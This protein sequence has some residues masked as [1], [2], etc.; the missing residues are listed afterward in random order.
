M[1]SL[2]ITVIAIALVAALAL[3]TIYYG[4][5]AFNKGSASAKAAQ[6]IMEGQQISGA[7]QMLQAESTLSGSGSNV[8][9]MATLVSEK[10]LTQVPEAYVNGFVDNGVLRDGELITLDICN[11]LERR[12]GR[13]GYT[14]GSAPPSAAVVAKDL[15]GK[16]GC[17]KG[18][19]YGAY[20]KL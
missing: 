13:H 19:N 15:P 11:E 5:N 20:Y 4:G 16:F 8:L 17:Y 18:D 12:A 9:E 7:W 3:A 1:F 2:I 10:Y 6:L 14:E